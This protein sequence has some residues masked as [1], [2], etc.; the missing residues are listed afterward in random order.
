MSEGRADATVERPA[1]DVV[2]RGGRVGVQG[3][4]EAVDV[5]YA[6]SLVEPVALQHEPLTGT[7][8]AA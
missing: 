3:G 1:R 7:Y 5:V 2:D 6:V 4:V 8:W